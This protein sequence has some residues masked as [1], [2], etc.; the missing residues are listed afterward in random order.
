MKK[1]MMLSI[2]IL[3]L[4]GCLTVSA[5]S[6]PED[7][8]QSDEAQIF[9]AKVIQC[10][11]SQDG[12]AVELLPV[13]TVKGDVSLGE[14]QIYEDV[15]PIG[16]FT[17][18]KDKAYLFAYTDEHNPTYAFRVTNYNPKKLSLIIPEE[19]R[20]NMFGRFEEYLNNG[21]YTV[22]EADRCVRLGIQQPAMQ[23][24]GELPPLD[25][26]ERSWLPLVVCGA[27][28]LLSAGGLLW[29]RKKY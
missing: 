9:F 24:D 29:W 10:E 20:R 2:V 15:I 12:I 14:Q 13:V 28:V 23:L 6:V 8:L 26:G 22:A 11:T 5:G 4:F 19:G 25:K 18:S 17:F 1:K 16:G 21:D 3:F 27:I 7:L